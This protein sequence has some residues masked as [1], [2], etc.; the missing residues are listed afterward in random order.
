MAL[1]LIQLVPN[2]SAC[3]LTPEKYTEVAKELSVMTDPCF[4][5]DSDNRSSKGPEYCSSQDFV[6]CSYGQNT[7]PVLP[8]A[9]SQSLASQQ[10]DFLLRP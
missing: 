9:Y 6:Y 4:G 1:A 7:F 3:R 10:R 2:E 8:L 5:S